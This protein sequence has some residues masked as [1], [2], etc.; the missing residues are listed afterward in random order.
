V[1]AIRLATD[2]AIPGWASFVVGLLVIIGLQAISLAAV[3]V[4]MVLNSRN[5]FTVIPR[6]DHAEY[7]SGE[8]SLYPC[9][10]R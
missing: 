6:R 10:V 8:V 7:V 9:S 4:F 2:L 1:V 5:Y 3:F